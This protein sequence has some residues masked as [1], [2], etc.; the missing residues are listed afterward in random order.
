MN[1]AFVIKFDGIDACGKTTLIDNV[2]KQL[3]KDYSVCIVKEFGDSKDTIIESVSMELSISQVIRLIA[4]CEDCEIDDIEREILWAFISRRTNRTIIPQLLND[5]QIILVDRSNLGNLAY[6]LTLN[7]QLKHVFDIVNNSVEIADVIFWI[8]TPVEVCE[9]RLLKRRQDIIEKK[10]KEFFIEVRAKY[11]YYSTK[12]DNVIK[13][14]GSQSEKD[15][16][17]SAISIIKVFVN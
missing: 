2:F 9:K 14:D 6:G 7:H 1:K 16:L 8:D 5:Y 10:G 4:K 13:L 3:Q 15:L 17:N 12:M 11:E